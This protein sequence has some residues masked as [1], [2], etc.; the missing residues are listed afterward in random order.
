MTPE[1]LT[2]FRKAQTVRVLRAAAA[3]ER[4]R[5]ATSADRV[6]KHVAARNDVGEIPPP[7]HPR[8][9]ARCKY[10]LAEFLWYYCR[11]LLNHRPPPEI[12]ETLIKPAQEC[13]L[14]GGQ[15]A[16]LAGRGTGK[17]TI[18]NQ[19]AQLWAALY[20]H[21][22][23]P[24][25]FAASL[26]AS[27]DAFDTL[28]YLMETSD[29]LAADFPA[30]ILPIRHLGGV[31]QRAAAQTYHGHKTGIIWGTSLVMLPTLRDSDG[32]LLDAG[33]GAILGA[34][35]Y[36]GSVRG[37]NVH[38]QR[39]DMVLIDDPQTRKIAASPRLV[40]AVIDYIHSDILALAG[41]NTTISAFLTI[42]PQRYGDVAMQIA[43]S[44]RFANW[45]RG[46]H[47][48]IKTFP[49]DWEKLATLFSEEYNRDA[50]NN[51]F[52]RKL[53]RAWY[54]ANR[55]LFAGMVTM[56]DEQYDHAREVDVVHHLLNLRAK[57]GEKSFNAE[58]QMQVVD[59]VSEITITPD[60][61]ANALNGSPRGVLPRGTDTVVGFCDV[62]IRAGAGLSWALIAFGPR[63]TAA[64]IDYGR[65]PGDGSPLVPPNSSDYM[66][67]RRVAAAIREA[68][69]T[70]A[71]RR[72]RDWKGRAVRIRALAFDRGWLPDVVHRTLYVL[73]KRVPLG[74]P[75]LSMRGFPWNKFG[76]RKDDILRHGDHVFASRSRYG[77]YLAY[78]APYW[79]EIMQAGFLETPL[80]EG[81][82]S[83]FGTDPA[84]HFA[85][86]TEIC[87]E[88]LVRKYQAYGG[89][90]TTTAWDWMTT[91]PE[92]WCD[93]ATGC[94]ALASWFRAYDALSS[95]ID[96]AA[97]G[98]TQP[99]QTHQDDLFD[100]RYNPEVR[101]WEGEK[102]RGWE[103]EKVRGE[104]GKVA[105][106]NL[107]PF[108]TSPLPTD[109]E[110]EG[111][112]V[113]LP[114]LAED[115]DLE[116]DMDEGR[117]P[118]P[119]ART[120]FRAVGNLGIKGRRVAARMLRKK[121]YKF[122][123]GKWKK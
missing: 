29:A 101:G 18:I 42:T 75:I 80:M 114:Q 86:A 48:F 35:G 71:A 8:L 67:N 6:A 96:P 13:I 34:S 2:A 36:G 33:C 31:S 44:E 22:R 97:L 92:H 3:K 4:R 123:K 88:K 70:I 40:E 47:P 23:F 82:I 122:K 65:I 117:V 84:V 116:R 90:E 83:L 99:R 63:R 73:R 50:A 79:R 26:T 43:T 10:D 89:R 1:E 14:H 15:V 68:V 17:T 30:V 113:E 119:L 20:G 59:A 102:V 120:K 57:L 115:G 52:D 91:G 46:I 106:S 95:T 7:K 108:P 98:I 27:K 72:I 69:T 56:D 9:K 111:V 39:P 78:M 74:F 60:V 45:N 16:K 105:S 32:N 51:D 66:R 24:F 109:D 93:A 107:P 76:T 77:E 25:T 103:G 53:S 12:C 110:S 118:D 64:V 61:V 104:E 85:F 58:I 41:H 5:D 112:G 81:S 94:F 38:G 100:P 49:K 121:I 11:E 62:N 54:I 87:A 21:R 28:K 19:G 37:K 55:D